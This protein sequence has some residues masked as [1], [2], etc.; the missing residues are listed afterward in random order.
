M[1]LAWK[2]SRH[3]PVAPLILMSLRTQDADGNP[4]E[5]TPDQ[6]REESDDLKAYDQNY[7]LKPAAEAGALLTWDLIGR[8]RR[9]PQFTPCKGEWDSSTLQR[10]YR[11][12]GKLW[13][14][15]DVGR[16]KDRSSVMVMCESGSHM[17][18]VGLL[19]MTGNLIT[20]TKQI[21]ALMDVVGHRIQ[22]IAIDRTGMGQGVV[23]A[24][25]LDYG[26]KILGVNFSETVPVNA[27]GFN[28]HAAEDKEKVV[29]ELITERMARLVLRAFLDDCVEIPADTELEES[30]HKP[31]RVVTEAGK[32]LIAAERTKNEDGTTDHA[33]DFWAMGLCFRAREVGAGGGVITAE[34][35][36]G[37]V[38][39][40]GSIFGASAGVPLEWFLLVRLLTQKTALRCH[41][42][43]RA[44]RCRVGVLFWL[45]CLKW[46][47]VRTP[48][49]IFAGSGWL[50]ASDALAEGR[51]A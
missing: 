19:R 38:V 4:I 13:V 31:E 43:A 11:T 6:A 14:G 41:H 25:V 34:Q 17:I 12:E 1:S 24:L 16:N 8:A 42:P 7:E 44:A 32:V 35:A 3:D 50:D 15:M 51:F 39:G 45:I 21:K 28:E 5:I 33:D 29:K 48:S 20:Q 10:L 37:I 49:K 2:Q 26:A 47:A 30:L 22:R 18:C 27:V 23:D 36:R 46:R 40:G 9:A